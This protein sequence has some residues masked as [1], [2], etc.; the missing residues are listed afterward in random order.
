MSRPDPRTLPATTAAHFVASAFDDG[1]AWSVD[2]S[3]DGATLL[4]LLAASALAILALAAATLLL[5]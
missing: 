5:V 1:E 3:R 2:D 4:R